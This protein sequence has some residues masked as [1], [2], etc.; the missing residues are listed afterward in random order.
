M[1][2]PRILHSQPA[3]SDVDGIKLYGITLADRT[4]DPA[5]FLTQLQQMKQS[6]AIDWTEHA[7]FAILHAG[8]E[9]NYLTLCW[10]AQGN[11]LF[12]RV[13]VEEEQG[14]SVDPA[15]YSFC[16]YDLEVMWAERQFFLQAHQSTFDLQDWRCRRLPPGL[17]GQ[18]PC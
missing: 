10:W 15:R 7:A 11:E 4:F 1:F 8:A 5:P 16:L 13:A 12:T 14:W 6:L 17:L 2:I 18:S 9:R 3:W